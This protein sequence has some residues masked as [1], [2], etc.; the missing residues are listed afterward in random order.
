MARPE[1]L[2]T[3]LRRNTIPRR[4]EIDGC[5]GVSQAS[6]DVVISAG[7]SVHPTGVMGTSEPTLYLLI[8]P[9]STFT[10]T[11]L[12]TI[13]SS[14]YPFRDGTSAPQIQT[15]PVPRLPPTSQEQATYWSEKFWPTVYKNHNPFGPH[16]SKVFRAEAELQP[17]AGTWMALAQE[18]ASEI[19][20]QRDGEP[21]GAVIVD[22]N[23]SGAGSAVVIVAGDARWY[24]ARLKDRK[25]Q[26]KG[27][28]AAHAV[29]RAVAMVARRHREQIDDML[30][31]S[32][33]EEKNIFL[34]R[35]ISPL[36]KGVYANS[37][38]DPQGY[39]CVGLD[40]YIT[41]EPCVMC[42]MALLHSRFDRVV[43]GQRMPLTGG[44]CAEY[45]K[46]GGDTVLQGGNRGSEEF[47]H[48]QSYGLFWRPE[49]NWKF[50]A[51]EWED[52]N[53][54]SL[55]RIEPTIHA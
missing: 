27:N 11:E 15:I 53:P 44:L 8:S 14:C 1:F 31:A 37:A 34:D 18:A 23:S 47:D 54:E 35:P 13:L 41:H 33:P 10:D 3:H 20:S 55:C 17:I 12:L 42:S 26:G 49:L 32:A 16:P 39:L 4:V 19:Q 9:A 7:S 52:E 6:H 28:V 46:K 25:L 50:L 21:I 5:D 38:V 40:I 45:S 51:W 30:R 43:F 2:P 22:R 29:M 24:G 48:G 36:E